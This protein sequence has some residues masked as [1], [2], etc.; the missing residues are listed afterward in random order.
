M[1]WRK[2]SIFVPMNVRIASCICINSV[3][4]AF[5]SFIFSKGSE[6]LSVRAVM[7]FA[8]VADLIVGANIRRT[9]RGGR[10]R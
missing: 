9:L 1:A 8:F 6:C 3:S 2:D 4:I 10:R 5:L 7:S